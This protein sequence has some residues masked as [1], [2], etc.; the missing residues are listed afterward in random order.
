MI[1][2][3]ARPICA[4]HGIDFA[5]AQGLWLDDNALLI[6]ARSDSEPRFALVGKL[7]N[8][9]WTALATMRAGKIRLIS[10][11]RARTSEV[12]EYERQDEAKGG[13]PRRT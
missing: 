1:G 2:T 7:G 3:I 10:V 4:K 5:Q 9:V 13:W 8:Q 12:Q 6:D 11:R